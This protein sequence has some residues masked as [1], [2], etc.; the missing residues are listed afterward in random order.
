MR[1]QGLRAALCGL[2]RANGMAFVRGE[3]KDRDRR[4]RS[5]LLLVHMQENAGH[6]RLLP[7]E[8]GRG[9]EIGTD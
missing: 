1:L 5:H 2:T 6:A 4:E 8:L 9:R 3:I 7:A